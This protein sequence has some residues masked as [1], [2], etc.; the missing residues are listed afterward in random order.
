LQ[1]IGWSYS[2][3]VIPVADFTLRFSFLFLIVIC[4]EEKSRQIIADL[5]A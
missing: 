5:S 3:V 4:S 2:K 1:Y